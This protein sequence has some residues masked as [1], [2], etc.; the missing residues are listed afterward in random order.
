MIG[1]SSRILVVEDDSFMRA[2]VVE[3][4]RAGGFDDVKEAEDGEEACRLLEAPDHVVLLVTDINLP[5]GSGTDVARS[6]KSH[7]PGIKIIFISADPGQLE[8]LPFAYRFVR[9]PFT[10]NDLITAVA[11]IGVTVIA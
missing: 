1:H 7:H 8:G 4:L 3:V 9:K 10:M 6:A 11:E 2:A 5:R